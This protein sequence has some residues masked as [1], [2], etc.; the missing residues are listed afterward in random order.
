MVDGDELGGD[1]GG[2]SVAPIL[3]YWPGTVSEA[4]ECCGP[5]DKK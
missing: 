2:D 4:P 5:S 1:S 3:I